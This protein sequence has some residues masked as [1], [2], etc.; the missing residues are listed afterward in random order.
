MCGLIQC[1][2]TVCRGGQVQHGRLFAS[3]DSGH[4]LDET[5]LIYN[6]NSKYE[7]RQGMELARWTLRS[8][9]QPG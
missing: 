7:M 6:N 3:G 2:Y 4:I 1:R 5:T 9:T 8:E